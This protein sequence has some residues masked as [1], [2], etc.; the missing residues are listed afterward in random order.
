MAH[1]ATRP[2]PGS[3]TI[4]ITVD[5]DNEALLRSFQAAARSGL[6]GDEMMS[7]VLKAPSKRYFDTVTKDSIA[8]INRL[9]LTEPI[10]G[11]LP[12]FWTGKYGQS[13]TRQDG[14]ENGKPYA[15]VALIPV[16]GSPS[17]AEQEPATY[18][19]SIELGARPS[20]HRIPSKLMRSRIQAWVESKLG[21][22]GRGARNLAFVIAQAISLRGMPP[23]RLLEFY[24][25]SSAFATMMNQA[26]ET[27]NRE[28][29]HEITSGGWSRTP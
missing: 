23:R 24:T 17:T 18:I 10:V 16:D 12:I 4:T 25:K 22:G 13:L 19:P 7:R 26:G 2:E 11:R 3:I 9:Y 27:L 8:E 5:V 29:I 20:G 14:V 6:S 1:Y 21:V 15:E 28:V